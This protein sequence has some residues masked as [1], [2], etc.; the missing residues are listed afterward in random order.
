MQ[1]DRAEERF[2]IEARVGGGAA[3]DIYRAQ[4]RV[5]G[6]PVALKFL[7]GTASHEEKTRFQREVAILAELRHPNIVEHVAH[8]TWSDGRPYLAMEWLDGEDLGKRTRREPLGM[9]DSVELVRRSA[10]ALAAVH[11]RG[12]VHRDLKLANIFLVK[13]RGTAIKLIDFGVVRSPE[14]DGFTTAPGSIVGTPHYMSPEQ[15]R[16]EAVD[17]RADVYALGSVLF[18]LLTGRNV[19]ET[20]HVIALLGRLVLEDPPRASSVRF[21]IPPALEDVIGCALSR[22]RDLRYPH[23]GEFARAL[24]RAGE[25][26]ND[27][28]ATERSNSQVRPVKKGRDDETTGSGSNSSRQTRPGMSLR[29]V[30]TCLLYDLS[31]MPGDVTISDN[32]SDIAGEDVRIERIAGGQ[33]VAVFGVER[34]RGDEVMRA[35]RTALQI[36]ADFSEARVVVANGHAH[37]FR[38]NLTGEALERAASQLEK[39]KP[40]TVRLDLHA[41]AALE[42]SFEC[43]RDGDGAL[44]IRED[45]RELAPRQVLGVVTPT[46]GR[47]RELDTLQGIYAE[48]VHDSFP[49]A[50]IVTGSP[51]IGK[52]RIRSELVQRLGL[53]PTPPEVLVCR[54]DRGFGA[55]SISALGKALRARMGVQDGATLA[56]QVRAVEVF[57]KSRLPRSLHFL[58]A[59]LGEVAGVRFPD[60]EDEALRAARTN[61][62]LMQAR[63]RMA[64]EAFFR[65]QAGRIPQL[66]L[67]ED[68]HVA[69]DTSLGLLEWLLACNDLRLFVVAFAQP[70][71][72]RTHPEIWSRA[73]YHGTDRSSLAPPERTTRLV[74]RPLSPPAAERLVGTILPNLE[75]ARRT[76]ILR[77]AAGNPLVLE[78]LARC[79]AEGRAELP[80]T[81]QSLVQLRLDRLTAQ[82]R[83]VLHSASVFGNVFWSGGVAAL[84]GH[85]VTADLATAEREEFLVKQASSRVAGETEWTFR[86]DVVR[87]AAYASLLDEDRRELHLRAGDWLESIG[88]ADLGHVAHHV[89]LGGALPRAASLYARATQQ[90]MGSFSQM[91][92]ALELSRRGLECGATGS[93]RAVLLVTKAH[94]CSRT[95]R[96]GEALEP[97]EQ[98]SQ[99]VPAGSTLWVEAQRLLTTCLVESGRAADGDARLGWALQSVGTALAPAD[100]S[101]LTAARVRALIDLNRPGLALGIADDA[102]RYARDAGAAGQQAMLRALDARLFA[103]MSIGNPGEA[104]A[105]GLE[106]IEKADSAGDSHLASRAR[107]N[108]ASTLNYLGA[109]EDARDLIDRALPDVRA[110]RL[111]LLEASALHN[112]SMSVARTGELGRGIDLQ[113]EAIR[114]ADECGGI[115]LAINSRLYECLM[116]TW[117]G[118]PADLK[119]ASVIASQ[120]VEACHPHP[121]LQ[122]IALFCQARVD[123]QRRNVREALEA[124]REAHRRLRD[125]PV[126]ELEELIRD[127]HVEALYAEGLIGEADEALRAAFEAVRQRAAAIKDPRLYGTFISRNLEARRILA[128]AEERVGLRLTPS[129]P[130]GPPPAP[131]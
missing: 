93:D 30:V 84:L 74:L 76:D 27:P 114:I 95:G 62:Q 10:Q 66:I 2:V 43:V 100:R 115:R 20:E 110:F 125:A 42:T 6:Q 124:A 79:A 119:R 5:T 78:E 77:R 3:G 14:P 9:R 23:A 8:G 36:L 1:Q 39:A 41:A 55:G 109:Y 121:G 28:P 104:V 40:G 98:A 101:L 45:P 128:L 18:R 59:F 81:V 67:V 53:A 73:G 63:I 127:C 4:D 34:S 52:S 86:Q 21:D 92:L 51:G 38:S 131:R 33:T 83:E 15:A 126:E 46:L 17:P 70:E 91:D 24:A 113:R 107:I 88:S 61:D 56:E 35:A 68:A 116:L 71:L 105:N 117:R 29:R 47:E 48:T 106:L 44:L 37:S 11:A 75:H 31:A 122:T 89:Q 111:R 26:N 64:L 7:R 99:L 96:L 12:V 54:G 90:A 118:E 102:I 13:G 22:S 103:L 120:I 57:V 60:R 32:L 130:P 87:D 16:G 97:A 19:F 49:R 112:L 85:E 123:L 25:L 65:T 129:S 82:V 50:T 80:L 58:A 69:D 94:V 72:D 108:T